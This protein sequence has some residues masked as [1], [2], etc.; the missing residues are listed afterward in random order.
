[1]THIYYDLLGI[2]QNASQEDIKK[3]YKK[4]AIA[5]HPDKGGDSEKFKK[6]ANAYQI[7]SD[8]N[9]RRDYDHLGDEMFENSQNGGD[10][11]GNPFN[12]MNPHDI[13][14]N[15]FRGGGPGFHGGFPF[16][17]HMNANNQNPVRR[18]DHVNNLNIN[19]NDAFFGAKKSIKINI[20]KV[21]LNCKSECNT[22][23]GKGKI[24]QMHR[25]GP[26]TQ[27]VTEMC[28][29]CGG[30]GQMHK[31]NLL[32]NDCNGTM[33]IQKEHKLDLEIPKGVQSGYQQVFKGYGEQKQNKNE[34][35]GDLVIKI[36]IYE[37]ATYKRRG[38]DLIHTS[39]ISF[40]ESIIGKNI[41]LSYFGESLDI[42]LKKFTII[43]PSIEY[44]IKGKGMPIEN[45][46]GSFGNLILIFNINYPLLANNTDDVSELVNV[47]SKFGI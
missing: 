4:A 44:V 40:K 23:Q 26:F 22:C 47:L 45:K 21:C 46:P 28:N 1:M 16:E 18:N 3:A 25:M 35:A 17:V 13:F 19:L 15:L 37:D 9:K 14:A 5:N 29:I 6:I 42:D 34:I 12:G 24:Q 7:L 33:K 8:E 30:S 20:T 2:S 43:Q 36:T 11:G 38:N 41:T 32:C 27:I 10:N 39:S 31:T